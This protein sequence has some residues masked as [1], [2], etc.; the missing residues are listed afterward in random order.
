MEGSIYNTPRGVQTSCTDASDYATVAVLLMRGED[1]KWR[2]CVFYLKSLSNVKI[3]YD[4]YDKEM[5]GIKQVLEAWRH[6]L[7][8]VKHKLEIW[9]D[10]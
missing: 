8:S 9:L 3:N 7:E 10:H 4:V 2:P 6:H 1:E 5:L